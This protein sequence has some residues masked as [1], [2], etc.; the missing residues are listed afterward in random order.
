MKQNI[1]DDMSIDMSIKKGIY[2]EEDLKKLIEHTII[3][4]SGS[5]KMKNVKSILESFLKKYKYN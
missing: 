3:N 2:T 1:D 5:D 4:T